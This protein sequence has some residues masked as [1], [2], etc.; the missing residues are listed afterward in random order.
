MTTQILFNRFGA[1]ANIVGG[2]CV[3][4]AYTL[5]PHHATPDVIAGSFWL[6]IHV[7]FALSL[8]FG[9]FGLFALY[10]R[11]LHNSRLIGLAGFILAVISLVGISGLNFFEAF[12]NPVIAIESPVF[13]HHYGAGTGIGHVSWL[14][15]LLGLFFLLGYELFCVDMLRT[16]T[17]NRSVLI[18][19]MLGTLIFG[20]GLSGFFPMIV[21]QVGSIMF[22]LGLVSLGVS[23]YI[24]TP[25]DRPVPA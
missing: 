25:G 4:L 24:Q 21:V 13:V 18:L 1:V 10:Q 12:I 22:G 23:S 16:K 3:G 9:V 7:L 20:I 17:V 8:L 2:V 11:H 14:F 5:H 6:I 15:P 19:T